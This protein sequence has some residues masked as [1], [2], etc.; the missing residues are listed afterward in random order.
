VRGH[1]VRQIPDRYLA[2]VDKYLH[3]LIDADKSPIDEEHVEIEVE[4]EVQEEDGVVAEDGQDALVSSEQDRDQYQEYSDD[5]GIDMHGQQDGAEEDE[6]MQAVLAQDGEEDDEELPD[7]VEFPEEINGDNQ[8]PEDDAENVEP[9]Q[10]VEMS[11]H[12]DL[13][14]E[15]DECIV[16]AEVDAEIMVRENSDDNGQ[17]IFNDEEETELISGTPGPPATAIFS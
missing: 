4:E 17:D 1:T 16:H 3:E 5:G 11:V 7:D 15:D 8:F 10:Q 6:D 9:V 14:V 2:Q 12:E 13:V